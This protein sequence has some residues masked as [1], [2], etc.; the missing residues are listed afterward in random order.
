MFTLNYGWKFSEEKRYNSVLG[1]GPK[2]ATIL[3]GSPGIFDHLREQVWSWFNPMFTLRR[4][5]FHACKCSELPAQVNPK[6]AF[7]GLR[8]KNCALSA[9]MNN[10]VF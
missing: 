10:L 7:S 9:E 6:S 1:I 3:G 4:V 5:G 2:K 8:P